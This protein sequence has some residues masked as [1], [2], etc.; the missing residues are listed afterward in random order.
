ME[1]AKESLVII[2]GPT[3]VGKSELAVSLAKR[4]GGSVLSADSMQVYQGMDIGSAKIT[5]REQQGIMHYLID[6]LKPTEEFHV[7]LFQQLAKQAFQEIR[8]EGR[9]PILCGGTG[10][11]IQAFL[12]DIDFTEQAKDEAYREELKTFADTYGP[13][14]LHS[15]LNKIDPEAA[16][17]I[18]PGNVKRVIRALE[19]YRQS[20]GQKISEHNKKERAKESAYNSFYFVLN[21]PREILYERIDRRVDRMMEQGLL[22]E[23]A[24]LRDSGIPRNAVSMQGLGYRELYGYLEG[25]YPLEEAVRLIKRNSRHFAK[26]QLTWFQR[27]PDAIWI[28][29]EEYSGDTGKILDFIEETV[30]S[31]LNTSEE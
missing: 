7:A 22:E 30:R 16:D 27:E 10:F 31:G 20:N 9:L 4:M 11:Y 3:A 25:D 15:R 17:A 8:E 5:P 2:A 24:G 21:E 26:R 6:I 18:P 1:N 13:K 14:E 12:Y 19:F 28:E 23:V 29:K